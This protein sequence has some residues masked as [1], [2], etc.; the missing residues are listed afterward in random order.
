MNIIQS[1]V[2]RHI[3]GRLASTSGSLPWTGA[4]GNRQ[5][6]WERVPNGFTA[7]W[8]DGSRGFG[9]RPNPDTRERAEAMAAE[10]P[11]RFPGFSSM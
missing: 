10:F 7:L 11:A 1:Y 6:D 2:W 4:P 9:H 8:P 5:D 3:S